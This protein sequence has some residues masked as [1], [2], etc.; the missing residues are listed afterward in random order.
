MQI[1]FALACGSMMVMNLATTRK[2]V[3][4]NLLFYG[5]SLLYKGYYWET[6]EGPLLKKGSSHNRASGHF[7]YN[8]VS[9]GM[10]GR[11]LA[12]EAAFSETAFPRVLQFWPSLNPGT[13]NAY[14]Y[15]YELGDLTS[16]FGLFCLSGRGWLLLTHDW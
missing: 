15:A 4:E 9:I 3:R 12:R 14:V 5:S 13:H 16:E 2:T 11:P 6:E 8:I 10:N 1:D 7:M